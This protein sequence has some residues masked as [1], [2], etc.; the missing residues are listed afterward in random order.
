MS[1]EEA[2][3]EPIEHVTAT[4]IR[5]LAP[6]M[7]E[8]GTDKIKAFAKLVNSYRQLVAITGDKQT[9]E[10]RLRDGDR[11]YQEALNG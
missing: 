7:T 1:N 10:E 2:N 3:E 5:A 11:E 6:G 4:V 8:A 9:A